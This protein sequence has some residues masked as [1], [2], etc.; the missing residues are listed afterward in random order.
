MTRFITRLKSYVS[1]A[2]KNI[3]SIDR[4]SDHSNLPRNIWVLV[5]L[6]R[7]EQIYAAKKEQGVLS[8]ALEPTGFRPEAGMTVSFSNND[9]RLSKALSDKSFKL[10]ERLIEEHGDSLAIAYAKRPRVRGGSLPRDGE[11]VAYATSNERLE[12]WQSDLVSGVALVDIN[13]QR[14]EQA[15]GELPRPL[16]TGFALPQD[17][18]C[19]LLILYYVDSNNHLGPLAERPESIRFITTP[20]VSP[21]D[22]ESTLEDFLRRA[23]ASQ[24]TA[25]AGFSY[26]QQVILFDETTLFGTPAFPKPYPKDQEIFGYPIKRV[27]KLGTALCAVGLIGALFFSGYQFA[28]TYLAKD[29][30]AE[31]TIT[32]QE[33]PHI[34]AKI[35]NEQFY[36]FVGAGSVN[37]KESIDLAKSVYQSG[38]RVVL[39]IDRSHLILQSYLPRPLKPNEDISLRLITAMQSPNPSGCT[40]NFV[41]T[42][43][44]Y[45]DIVINYDCQTKTTSRT[46]R[47]IPLYATK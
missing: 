46:S 2:T 30:I 42:D 39:E 5:D 3:A 41:D 9:F 37:L 45:T 13:L 8:L 6:D 23:D 40:R 20:N 18:D 12:G 35:A 25:E 34:P 47:F 16:I 1:K 26:E 44:T 32:S 10:K 27:I 14:Y 28:R 19:L 4:K 7:H 38:G 15:H 29:K 17:R 21:A 22:Y 36:A 43:N 11:T 33:L 31:L 24:T